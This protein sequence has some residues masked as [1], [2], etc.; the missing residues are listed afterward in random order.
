MFQFFTLEIGD[1][2]SPSPTSYLTAV[3]EWPTM[4]THVIPQGQLQDNFVKSAST[5]LAPASL[6]KVWAPQT[7]TLGL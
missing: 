4:V 7:S 2:R 3:S 6:G 5:L 1:F